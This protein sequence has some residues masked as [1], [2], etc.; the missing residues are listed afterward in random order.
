MKVCGDNMDRRGKFYKAIILVL[1]FCLSISW[2]TPVVKAATM[3]DIRVGL[4][5]FYKDKPMLKIKTTNISLGYSI[6]NSF[7]TEVEFKSLSGFTF[8]A[9]TGYFYILNQTFR[10]YDQAMKVVKQIRSLGVECHPVSV[11]RNYWKVYVGNK[12]TIEE[13]NQVRTALGTKYDYTYTGPEKDNG[14]RVLVTGDQLTFL[15]DGG[16]KKAYPQFKP[17]SENSYHTRVLDLGARQYRGRI[18]IGRYSSQALTAVNVIN[19][20]SYLYGVVPG[21]MISS[22]PIQALRAQAVCSRSYAISKTTY[23]TD[24]NISNGY[25]I[26]DTTDNQVYKGYGVETVATN[27]AVDFTR[28]EVITYQGKV[29]TAFYY[30]TSGGRTEDGANV[31]NLKAPYL[32]SVVDEFEREPE[33]EPWV[34]AMPMSEVE[35]R[36]SQAGIDVGVVQKVIPEITTASNRVYSLKI[37]GSKN[38]QVIQSQKIREVFE[39]YSTKFEIVKYEDQSDQ[40]HVLSAD[41]TTSVNLND[42]SVMSSDDNV[43]SLVDTNQRIYIVK[44][45]NNLTP[46]I[47]D[48]PTNP[49]VIYFVGLGFGHGVGMSQSG[50]KGLASAGYS[51]WKIIQYYYKGCRVVKL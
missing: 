40:V 18:E 7:T 10:K 25:E 46:F 28:G 20:E 50:A 31:W 12:K 8:Q 16:V 51:Y 34:I 49:E 47:K 42:C 19:I 44:S 41:S 6:Q 11:Y 27:A 35:F 24:S 22:W 38:S 5:K 1:I 23:R 2:Y 33:K 26:D 36:L 32:T 30:S 29:I 21:E 17:I 3:T 48:S 14:H 37:I 43:T 45:S 4:A 39:L 15:Y 9:A 13:M